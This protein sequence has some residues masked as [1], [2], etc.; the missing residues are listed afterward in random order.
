[1]IIPDPSVRK[2]IFGFL[3]LSAEIHDVAVHIFLILLYN[4]V[5]IKER[6]KSRYPDKMGG[7][8]CPKEIAALLKTR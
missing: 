1:M 8:P 2:Q 7:I 5:H 6:M 4:K 3:H